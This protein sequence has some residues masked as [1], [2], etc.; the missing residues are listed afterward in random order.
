MTKKDLLIQEA[1]RYIARAIDS[2]RKLT[3]DEISKGL[4]NK[5]HRNLDA[6]G[7][8]RKLTDDEIDKVLGWPLIGGAKKAYEMGH[9]H[10]VKGVTKINAEN[11]YGIF[12]QKYHQGYEDGNA[13]AA[14]KEDRVDRAAAATQRVIDRRR[15]QQK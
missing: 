14:S 15:T 11:S 3:D 6:M 5:V 4:G 13:S 1:A 8:E 10:G 2:R 7:S 9:Q 12:A